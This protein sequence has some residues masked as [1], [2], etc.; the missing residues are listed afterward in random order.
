MAS[1]NPSKRVWKILQ[2]IE[3]WTASQDPIAKNFK[4]AE[5][6][7]SDQ[8]STACP[9]DTPPTQITDVPIIGFIY[10]SPQLFGQQGLKI[11]ILIPLA[12]PQEAPKIYMCTLIRHPNIEEKGE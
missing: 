9:S 3:N 12:Y 4:V 10:P 7:S 11:K 8:S 2:M 6:F 5:N 1:S